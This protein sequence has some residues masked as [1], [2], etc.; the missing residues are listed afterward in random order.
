[1]D[2]RDGLA[3]DRLLGDAM[4]SLRLQ[5]IF[6]EKMTTRGRE[7]RAVGMQAVAGH[8][9]AVSSKDPCLSESLNKFQRRL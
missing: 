9:L 1:M 3:V 2:C 5:M 6:L 4:S 7:L 8:A